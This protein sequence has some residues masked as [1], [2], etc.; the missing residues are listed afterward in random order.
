MKPCTTCFGAGCKH[1]THAPPGVSPARWV[2][3]LAAARQFDDRVNHGAGRLKTDAMQPGTI[4]EN[5]VV[6]ALRKQPGT[7]A[8]PTK[9]SRHG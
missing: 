3:L 4:G 2:T 8:D 7:V 1:C 9:E 6:P 5:R